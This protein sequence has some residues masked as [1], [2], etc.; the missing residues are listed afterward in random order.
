MSLGIQLLDTW[1]QTAVF[2]PNDPTQ[3]KITKYAGIPGQYATF[4]FNRVRTPGEL[5]GPFTSAIGTG[6]GIAFG[7]LLASVAI[8]AAGYGL[9]RAGILRLKKPAG[10]SGLGFFRY[11]KRSRRR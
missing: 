9:R 8:G 6:A 1:E 4:Y 11:K 7:M 10:M 5:K 3:K 2:N